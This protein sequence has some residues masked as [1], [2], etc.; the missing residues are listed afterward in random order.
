MLIPTC[1]QEHTP[2]ERILEMRIESLQERIRELETRSSYLVLP[3]TYT[4]TRDL[5]P[6]LEIISRTL[7][8][9]S[10]TSLMLVEKAPNSHTYETVV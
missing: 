4:S 3:M 6:K 1:D 10:K 2:R 5:S 7:N 8:D 9:S